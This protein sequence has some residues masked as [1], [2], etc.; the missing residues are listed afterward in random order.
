MTKD[1]GSETAVGK[2]AVSGSGL[3]EGLN[4]SEPSPSA[5]SAATTEPNPADLLAP[6]LQAACP[7]CG[8]LNPQGTRECA[9]CG[10][11]LTEPP[12][13]EAEHNE[14]RWRRGR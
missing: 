2:H 8:D 4:P 3:H 1:Q 7:R 11:R 10:A 5:S 6:D 9:G 12:F 14:R 13:T